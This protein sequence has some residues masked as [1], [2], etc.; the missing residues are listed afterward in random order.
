MSR[1]AVITGA[2]GGIGK[3]LA[4]QFAAEGTKVVLNYFTSEKAAEELVR[5]INGKSPDMAFA[6][7]ADLSKYQEVEAM[8]QKTL[9]KWGQI[10]VLINSATGGPINTPFRTV[11]DFSGVPIIETEERD[12]D[13]IVDATLKNVFN[14]IKAIAPQMIK[15]KEGHI[16]SIGAAPAIIGREGWAPFNA[17]KGGLIALSRSA[18]RELGKHNIK[19][20]IVNP[21]Y[22]AHPGRDWEFSQKV[23]DSTLLKRFQTAEEFSRFIVFLSKMQ[24]VSGQNFF[25]E[26]RIII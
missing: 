7:K 25:V 21:G 24:N 20:N 12:W 2:S 5:E 8:V 9:S 22:I 4:R 26:S 18:A 19:V 14:C 6:C 16:I 3:E 13:W 23:A 17:A 1:V 11:D 10:H 15:Q